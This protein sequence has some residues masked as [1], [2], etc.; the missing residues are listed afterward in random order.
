MFRTRHPRRKPLSELEQA[1]LDLI[2]RLEKPSA[3]EIRTELAPDRALKDS[4]V[5]TVLRRLEDKGYV[6]HDLDGRTFRF[7]AVEAPEELAGSALR[8]MIDRFWRGSMEQFLTGMV[9]N[10]LLDARELKRLAEKIEKAKQGG[11]AK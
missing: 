10:E 5:R 3:E 6:R 8:Q 2:W 7:S 11:D 9:D 1:V 4:T